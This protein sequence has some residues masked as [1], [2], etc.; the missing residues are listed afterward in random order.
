MRWRKLL[1][2]VPKLTEANVLH[3]LFSLICRQKVVSH[4]VA[5]LLQLDY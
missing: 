4:I 5:T 2:S 1:L 3:S